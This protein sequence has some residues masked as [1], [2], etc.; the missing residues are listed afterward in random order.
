[1]AAN[2]LTSSDEHYT[3]KHIFDS[4]GIAFD[5]DVASPHGGLSSVPAKE[6]FCACCKPALEQQW[7]G[8]VWMNPPFSKPTPF[9]DKFIQHGNGIALLVVSRSRWFGDLW[10][11]ADAVVPTPYNLK[12][13]RPDEKPKQISFQTMLFAIGNDNVKALKNMDRRVR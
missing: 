1:V 11:M 2:N 8:N 5:L 13:D 9:V 6:W 12:F 10:E 7:F 3:P 4:L